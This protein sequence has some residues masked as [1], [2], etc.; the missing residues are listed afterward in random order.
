M[1]ALARA[2]RKKQAGGATA[3]MPAGGAGSAS[4]RSAGGSAPSAGPPPFRSAA[5]LGANGDV[6]RTQALLQPLFAKPVLTERLL[7]K[8]PF[9][10]LHDIFTALLA[11]TRF[12]TGLLTDAQLNPDNVTDKEGK[13]A[14]LDRYIDAIGVHLNTHVSARSSKI[15]AGS[16]PE[17]TNE[18]LQLLAMAATDGRS[19][20]AAVRAVLAGAKQLGADGAPQA[21]AA[22]PAPAAAVAAPQQLSVATAAPA[23][24]ARAFAGPAAA[25]G[26]GPAAAAAR[27]PR[28][29]DASAA[30]VAA[31]AGAGSG[32]GSAAGG[33]GGDSSASAAAAQGGSQQQQRFIRPKTAQRRP[34]KIKE[35]T[36][37]A[38]PAQGGAGG[39]AGAAGA[40]PLSL[41]AEGAGGDDDDDDDVWG[42]KRGDGAA[43]AGRSAL[44]G[45]GGSAFGGGFGT[46]AGMGMGG[47]EDPFSL[48]LGSGGAGGMNLKGN[49]G[50]TPMASGGAG[51]GLGLMGAGGKHTR[52]ILSDAGAGG[53]VGAEGEGDGSGGIRMGRIV[54]A[55]AGAAGGAVGAGGGLAPEQLEALRGG[56]QALC[57]NTQVSAAAWRCWYVHH[58]S[59][60]AVHTLVLLLR[61]AAVG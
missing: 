19:S 8:P 7:S 37:S 41:M 33:F 57:A 58:I 31:G 21:G 11:S 42:G 34:P 23:P 16:E 46:G 22:A 27:T 61:V 15:V 1:Q 59:S 60:H 52:D 12:A 35:P 40:I 4:G 25:A 28:G 18:M 43:S 29:T 3:L 47:F 45:T 17:R 55:G 30:G 13:M 9:R 53:G 39:A 48:G 24:D 32:A 14:V 49:A 36:A 38:G 54:R 44:G 6:A 50:R 26:G 5:E 2:V 20:D 56:I 51:G 10:F